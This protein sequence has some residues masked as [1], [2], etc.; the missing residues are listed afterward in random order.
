M[1]PA[2]N[3]VAV[4]GERPHDDRRGCCRCDVETRGGDEERTGGG[5]STD[6]D[7]AGGVGCTA[8]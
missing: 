7:C 8:G 2:E 4:A 6:E 5:V 3:Y 1:L